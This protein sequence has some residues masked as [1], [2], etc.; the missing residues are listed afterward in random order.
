MN[1]FTLDWKG[2]L[3][4]LLLALCLYFLGVDFGLF[5][6]LD[7]LYFLVISA[8]VTY[9]GS[10]AK[11]KIKVFEKSRSIKNV[12]A[13]GMGPLIFAIGIYLYS[14]LYIKLVLGLFIIGFIGSVAAITADKF[15]SEIGV[16]DGTPTDII[17]LKK[18]KKGTSGGIT[19]LG[20]LAGL[21]G[22][23]AIA[24]SYFAVAPSLPF[25]YGIG[26]SAI[27]IAGFVG[28]LADSLAGHYEE[29]S[30]GNK[31]S[32]NFICSIAGGLTAML[33]ILSAGIV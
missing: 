32:S 3:S 33:I 24:L 25:N 18:I 21:L 28:T 29:L 15:S 7:M 27:A 4:A 11:K 10:K 20:L 30:I 8:V 5:L 9:T 23:L 31:Y 19:L 22:S 2:A 26:F 16:L 1:F 12:V 13:N 14:M 17:T 6:V